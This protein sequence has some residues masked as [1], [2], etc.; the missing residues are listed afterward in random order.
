MLCFPARQSRRCC[1]PR[2]GSTHG[3]ALRG[4]SHGQRSG[5]VI[6]EPWTNESRGTQMTTEDRKKR[7]N[8]M[9]TEAGETCSERGARVISVAQAAERGGSPDRTRPTAQHGGHQTL[10]HLGKSARRVSF[11]MGCAHQDP[12]PRGH[13]SRG[14]NGRDTEATE[15]CCGPEI[16]QCAPPPGYPPGEV[17]EPRR[18][19][20]PEARLAAAQVGLA[21]YCSK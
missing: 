5:M 11:M 7:G 8:T 20:N 4:P 15:V 2:Q 12:Y 1:R 19:S 18:S 9:S 10:A 16:R 13:V 21:A 14:T 17:R 6:R 3:R